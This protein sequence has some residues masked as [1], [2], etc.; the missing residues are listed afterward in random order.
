LT[1]FVG[2]TREVLTLKGTVEGSDQSESISTRRAQV[3]EKVEEAAS[4]ILKEELS[5]L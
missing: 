1:Q 5:S 4:N 2:L 3:S